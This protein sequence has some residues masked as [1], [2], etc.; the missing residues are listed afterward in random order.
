M[1]QTKI[2]RLFSLISG[3]WVGGFIAIGFLVV[4]V[5]FTTLGDRQVAGYIAANLFK[6]NSYIGVGLCSLLMLIANRLVKLECRSYRQIRWILLLMLVC[7]V[8]AACIIIPW[9]NALRDQALQLGISIRDTSN[10]K[11]FNLLHMV[12]STVF[13]IQSILG[14]VLVWWST[15]NAD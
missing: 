14:I 5:L 1:S 6:I 12:S 4:P 3:L 11:L 10:A 7:A 13:I 2:Q 9:M 15:K 8:A